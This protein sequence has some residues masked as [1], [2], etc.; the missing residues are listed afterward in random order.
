MRE[1]F[2]FKED[3]DDLA[4][5]TCPSRSKADHGSYQAPGDPAQRDCHKH[6]SKRDRPRRGEGAN[7]SDGKE[8]RTTESAKLLTTYIPTDI[9]ALYLAGMGV[10]PQMRSNGTI[11]A[12][13]QRC[14]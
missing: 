2:Q 7:G 10:A 13:G 11:A 3:Q 8:N 5:S 6:L 12:L 9:V 1:F 14:S 4:R